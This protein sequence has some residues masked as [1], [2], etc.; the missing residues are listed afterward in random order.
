MQDPH[1][2][3]YGLPG[4]GELSAEA[5]HRWVR[6]KSFVSLK[7]RKWLWRQSPQNNLNQRQVSHAAWLKWESVPQNVL[8]TPFFVSFSGGED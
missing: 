7:C 5:Q 1:Q 6:R 4:P 8:K 3:L 2:G